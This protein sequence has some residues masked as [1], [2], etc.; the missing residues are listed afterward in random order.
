MSEITRIVDQLEREHAGEPWHGSSVLAQLECLPAEQAAAHPVRGAH[1]IWE[2]VLHMTA[3]KEEV[4]RRVT[5]E[6]ASEPARG[7]WPAVGDPSPERWRAAV[8]DLTRAHE[9]LVAGLRALDELA[10][11][12]PI[13]DPRNAE[14][15]E[16]VTVYELLHGIVQHDA[17]H[18]GQI[19]LLKKAA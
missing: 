12:R 13:N 18:S 1:S 10:L 5:G 14:T 16:G 9:A 3:W 8:A 6:P 2:L 17:Y 7:D 19:G 4:L 11:W 15:R